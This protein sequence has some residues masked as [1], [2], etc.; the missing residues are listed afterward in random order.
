MKWPV[1]T[2]QL[3]IVKFIMFENTN[4]GEE[5]F[6]CKTAQ[7][8]SFLKPERSPPAGHEKECTS[9][10][11]LPC[12]PRIYKCFE[13]LWPQDMVCWC[14]DHIR[15]APFFSSFNDILKFSV[16]RTTWA[17]TGHILEFPKHFFFQIDICILFVILA[18]WTSP[19]TVSKHHILNVISYY[20]VLLNRGRILIIWIIL[21]ILPIFTH[22]FPPVSCLLPLLV[23]S[24]H[25]FLPF[26]SA[27][28]LLVFSSTSCLPFLS[29]RFLSPTTCFIFLCFIILFSSCH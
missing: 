17:K 3:L 4:M 27:F 8:G 22:L 26:S 20:S 13:F 1:T 15:L 19:D 14:A 21:I 2:C 9:T 23:S 16:K 25:F 5:L 28:P 10:S 18:L 24:H 11:P 7:A 12:W 6:P 29:S